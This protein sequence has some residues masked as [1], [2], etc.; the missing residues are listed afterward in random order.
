MTTREQDPLK[1]LE[2]I[3]AAIF[4]LMAGVTAASI[5]GA[6]VGSGSIPGLTAEVCVS[7]SVG[8]GV[9]FQDGDNGATPA[10]E[11][12]NLRD[13]IRWHTEQVQ[14]CDPT[15]DAATR[16]L[17]LTGLTVWALAPLLFFGLLWRLLRN[18]RRNGFFA[19]QIPGG[20]RLLGGFLLGWAALGFVVT[21]VVNAALINK[22]T[23]DDVWFFTSD[24]FPWLLILLGMAFLAL[25][26]VMAQAVALRADTEATI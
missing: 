11:P 18:A 26:R 13:G 16:T 6:T 4:L 23:D 19:D 7:S 3:V 21:G 15:P 20:L 24:E 1:A 5:I 12:M 8:D 25:E 2:R 9:V 22:M 17:G 14:V 10:F